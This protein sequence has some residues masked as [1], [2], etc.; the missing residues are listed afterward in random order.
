[1]VRYQW[2]H[3]EQWPPAQELQLAALL[4]AAT[5]EMLHTPA[6]HDGFLIETERLGT[7]ILRFRG[8]TGRA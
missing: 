8:L 7:M 2:P 4:P 1:M 3:V 5:Y 6:G